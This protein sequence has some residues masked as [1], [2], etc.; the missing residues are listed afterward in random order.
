MTLNTLGVLGLKL[1]VQ[2]LYDGEHQGK[3]KTDLTVLFNGDAL[4]ALFDHSRTPDSLLWQVLAKTAETFDN[5]FVLPYLASPFRPRGL[6]E[7]EGAVESCEVV[8]HHL[9][10]FYCKY[11]KNTF[12]PALRAAQ[13]DFA[14]EKRLDFF[15]KFYK[16]GP[17]G[18]GSGSRFLVRYL[19]EVIY[20][21]QEGEGISM[22]LNVRNAGNP[23]EAAS[24]NLTVGEPIDL[25][26][27][28]STAPIGMR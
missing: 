8:A 23:S 24:P 2:E 17:F 20:A 28:E 22:R 15:E 25:A 7:V 3:V 6:D 1:G 21:L 5:Q 4:T 10:G 9:G 13:A 16:A 27:L 19:A 12:L 26:L 18:S 11:F 14:P